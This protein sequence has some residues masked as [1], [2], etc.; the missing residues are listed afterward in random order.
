MNEQEEKKVDV[1]L[2]EYKIL[3]EEIK[4]RIGRSDKIISVGLTIV[5]AGV[6]Y[7]MKENMKEILIFL[8]IGLYCVIFYAVFNTT[9]VMTLG[10]Y[11]KYLAE[12]INICFDEELLLW[13]NIAKKI[14]HH[15]I[16]Q[17]SLYI[18][19]FLCLIAVVLLGYYSASFS[20]SFE[21][22][23]T[24]IV[25]VIIMSVVLLISL[26]VLEKAFEKSYAISKNS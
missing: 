16:A 10:G 23:T 6:V 8:P 22:K 13:E 1:L 17:I 9:I 3:S 21:I 14:I 4:E 2:A 24:Y 19:Y 18:I 7:G 11:R 26:F 12:K 20:Y 15:N 5:G 25:V